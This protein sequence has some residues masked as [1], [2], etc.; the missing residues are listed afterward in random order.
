MGATAQGKNFQ[1]GPQSLFDDATRVF[2]TQCIEL[3]LCQG[4]I[5]G[6]VE[7][8]EELLACNDGRTIEPGGVA[9]GPYGW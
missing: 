2:N 4:A 1:G 8:T 3:P 7:Q 9:D 5:A 6:W